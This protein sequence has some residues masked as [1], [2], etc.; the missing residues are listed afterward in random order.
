VE[1]RAW[2]L[3]GVGVHL[4]SE[5]PLPRGVD[6]AF[7]RYRRPAAPPD[8][9]LELRR[10]VLPKDAQVAGMAL[11]LERH[12][13]AVIGG[14][15]GSRYWMHA[16]SGGVAGDLVNDTIVFYAPDITWL[17]HATFVRT[18]FPLAV[19]LHL[20]RRGFF[21][22]HAA[23]V[24]DPGG[25][26][27]VLLG[28]GGAGKSTTTYQLVR[29]GWRY[30]CDDGVLLCRSGDQVSAHAFLDEFHL[31]RA[32]TKLFPELEFDDSIREHPTKGVVAME[33]LHPA[34][35]T[36]AVVPSRLVSLA[37]PG[38]SGAAL[39]KAFA[40]DNPLMTVHEPEAYL[41][42]LARLIG[43]CARASVLVNQALLTDP[44]VVLRAAIDGN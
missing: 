3:H 22:A 32:A 40:D 43:Q 18:L 11:R 14:Y 41:D 34:A 10:G 35:H 33:R 12:G 26:G 6:H 15:G 42:V 27:W 5:L 17:E 1:T 36:D 8:I 21:Y 16:G 9:R 37:G 30:V 24:V 7:R 25:A 23:V 4:S 38:T 28:S 31:E 2:D 20:A 44:E 39:V 19:V 29:R 13:G